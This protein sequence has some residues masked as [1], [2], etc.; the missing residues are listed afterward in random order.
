MFTLRQTFATFLSSR[1]NLAT[2]VPL[3]FSSLLGHTLP[4][5]RGSRKKALPSSITERVSLRDVLNERQATAEDNPNFAHFSSTLR[6]VLNGAVDFQTLEVYQDALIPKLETS[7]RELQSLTV[8]PSAQSLL[9]P[10]LAK[11][12]AFYETLATALDLVED[13]LHDGTR[14]C[15]EEAISLLDVVGDQMGRGV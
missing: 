13:F 6:G 12:E 11:T 4:M 5:T 15:L 7:R 8:P 10:L 9:G 1:H 14:E 2:I 3:H